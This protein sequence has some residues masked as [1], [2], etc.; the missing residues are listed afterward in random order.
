MPASCWVP[1]MPPALGQFARCLHAVQLRAC[2]VSPN[3][4]LVAVSGLS[5]QHICGI[6]LP[7]TLQ[8]ESSA[9]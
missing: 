3:S 8:K 1:A 2:T 5:A 7:S 6:Y 4:S 9:G